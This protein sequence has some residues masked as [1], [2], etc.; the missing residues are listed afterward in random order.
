MSI[1]QGRGREREADPLLI[2]ESDVG[3]HPG[4]LK[5]WPEPKADSRTEPPKHTGK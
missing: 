5:S 2:R 4:T 1:S 3:L